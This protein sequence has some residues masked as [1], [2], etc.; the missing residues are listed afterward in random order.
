MKAST[1][2]SALL[3]FTGL[4]AASATHAQ[5]T[6][7]YYQSGLPAVGIGYGLLDGRLLQEARVDMDNFV[8]DSAVEV[9]ATYA[10]F[11]RD[12][13]EAYA[14]TGLRFGTLPALPALLGVRAYPF[15]TRRVGV[16]VEAAGLLLT[17]EVGDGLI[18]RGSIGAHVRFG[19][20]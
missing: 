17:D 11:R 20:E 9:V 15:A 14:G 16:Q 8:E 18:L 19:E 3:L 7:G 6:V 2:A 13:Y 4:T 1:L 10:F 5:L 12:D